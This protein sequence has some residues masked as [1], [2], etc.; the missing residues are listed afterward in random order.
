MT[1]DVT[2]GALIR[3]KRTLAPVYYLAADTSIVAHTLAAWQVVG[4]TAAQPV[5]PA[6]SLGPDE[7]VVDLTGTLAAGAALTLPTA[8][9][10]LAAMPNAYV[11]EQFK[12]R[13]KNDSSGAFSWTV[14]TNTGITL[15]GTATVAQATFRDFYV[16]ITGVGANAAITV[17]NVGAGT[18]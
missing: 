18:A 17:N 10:I 3:L 14:T 13:I 9:A 6:S 4:A 2:L 11:G 1:G 15:T 8:A 12:L 5:L 7:V 16:M